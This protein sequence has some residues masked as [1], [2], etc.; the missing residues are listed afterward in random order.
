MAK[1]ANAAL[2]RAEKSEVRV[3]DLRLTA[4]VELGEAKTKCKEAGINFKAWASENVTYAYESVRKLAT[5]GQADD[6]AKALEDLR[7]RTKASAS[8]TREKNADKSYEGQVTKMIT[9]MPAKEINIVVG[10][11]IEDKGDG[12]LRAGFKKLK[13][14][15]KLKFLAWAAESVGA[16]ATMNGIAL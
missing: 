6:P 1:R 15:D 10:N 12:A 11:L 3:N 16:E 4:A 5:I 2:E 7:S 13:K 14:S 9:K 8:K